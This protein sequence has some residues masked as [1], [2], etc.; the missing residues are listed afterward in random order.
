[1]AIIDLTNK[2]FGELLVI[3]LYEK[4]KR[5]ECKW[6]CKCSCG[7][8]TVVYGS[9][10]RKGNTVSCGC[11]MRTTHKTH[12]D[13]KTRLYRIWQKIHSRCENSNYEHFDCY[14]GRGIS[15]CKEWDDFI[16]FK[17]WAM[18]NGY[19]EELTIDRINVNGNYEPA[20][21]RWI[22]RDEQMRN[23]RRNVF[24]TIDGE[25]HCLRE[26]SRILNI[27]IQTICS[28]NKR[29]MDIRD[30]RRICT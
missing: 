4:D 13:S 16:L 22:T 3:R 23:T 21:C 20:N 27:P 30:G 6:L 9:H 15:V 17:T 8:E 18:D 1:M 29:G 26:W 28:R 14:G 25:K 10:L 19:S 12:G 5:S 24:V 11:V 2:Q 7:N